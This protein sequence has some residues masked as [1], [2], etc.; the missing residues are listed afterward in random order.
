MIKR[1]KQTEDYYKTLP[2]GFGTGSVYDY[3]CYLVSL[4]NG[5]SAFGYD[6]TPRTF[7]Q[8][9]KDK[10]AWT[11][12]FKNYINVD[13]LD[14]ILPDIFKSFKSIEPTP[15]MATIQWYLSRDYI[16]VAKVNAK[17][18]GGSGSHFVFVEYIKDGVTWIYDPWFGDLKKV[19]DRYGNLGNLLGLRIFGVVR[20]SGS[21]NDNNTGGETME[22][23]NKL[24]EEL[25]GKS[26][27][28]DEGVKLIGEPL[29]QKITELKAELSKTGG[30]LR[31]EIANRVEQVSKLQ[32][33]LLN[34]ENEINN[35]RINLKEALE[36]VKTVEVDSPEL[37]KRVNDLET[38]LVL[39]REARDEADK[40]K[41]RA[42]NEV[43]KLTEQLADLESKYLAL[44]KR[45]GIEMPASK[46]LTALW[47]A[48]WAK[49][50]GTNIKLEE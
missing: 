26:T 7:N 3:G 30:E 20:K 43:A 9:L 24:F 46:L 37:V 49:L 38:S 18:I 21:N 31:Q 10:N 42:L 47:A 34:S 23:P 44:V 11:G 50:K 8:F 2:M 27:E 29:V 35:L 12:E 4:V 36:N 22:I 32:G 33:R 14:D 48:L 28:R 25:V 40:A 6:Y 16:I 13:K 5:L 15:D 45:R 17:A 1:Y 41:G 39:E 19:T